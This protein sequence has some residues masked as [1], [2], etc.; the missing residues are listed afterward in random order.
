MSPSKK[1]LKGVSWNCGSQQLQ[2][3]IQFKSSSHTKDFP[4]QTP[5]IHSYYTPFSCLTYIQ[6]AFHWI[7]VFTSTGLLNYFYTLTLI[8]PFNNSTMQC[9]TIWKHFTNKP[10]TN[11]KSSLLASYLSYLHIIKHKTKSYSASLPRINFLKP[12]P[13]SVPDSLYTNPKYYSYI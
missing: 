7:N 1:S 8:Y 4:S 13:L 9:K 2:Y 12:S 3:F 10:L 11:P 5:I 6:T